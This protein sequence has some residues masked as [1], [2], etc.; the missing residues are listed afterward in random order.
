MPFRSSAVQTGGAESASQ[1]LRPQPAQG[2]QQ[3]L[4]AGHLTQQHQLQRYK[5]L[6]HQEPFPHQRQRRLEKQL[7]QLQSTGPQSREPQSM[8]LS[9]QAVAE[10]AAE[11]P[12]S[13]QS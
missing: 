8:S 2:R 7:E 11:L 9:A 10:Q 3:Q 6:L 1:E 5:H 12:Q 4:I 13:S